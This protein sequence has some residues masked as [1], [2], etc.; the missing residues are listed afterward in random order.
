MRV[1]SEGAA[2]ECLSLRLSL[3]HQQTFIKCATCAVFAGRGCEVDVGFLQTELHRRFIPEQWDREECGLHD[4]VGD[5]GG[6]AASRSAPFSWLH[7]FE[8]DP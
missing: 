7:P 3:L 8:N 5:R 1:T 6:A 4:G 2:D